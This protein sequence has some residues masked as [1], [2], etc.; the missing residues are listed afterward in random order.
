LIA[1]N[2]SKSRVWLPYVK[3]ADIKT[4]ILPWLIMLLRTARDQN[5]ME[6]ENDQTHATANKLV[7]DF[8]RL[9]HNF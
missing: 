6:Y 9:L 7:T 5:N 3:H 4:D 8:S 1:A 2:C